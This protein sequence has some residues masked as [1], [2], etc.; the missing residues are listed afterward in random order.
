MESTISDLKADLS[1]ANVSYAGLTEKAQLVE[2]HRRHSR[3][4]KPDDSSEC[5]CRICFEEEEVDELIAPCLCRGT[6]RWVHRSCLDEWRATK[7]SDSFYSCPSCKFKYK[8]R[9]RK[10]PRTNTELWLYRAKVS[11][12]LLFLILALCVVSLI[13]A[14]VA[15]WLLTNTSIIFF[16]MEYVPWGWSRGPE[17]S[18]IRTLCPHT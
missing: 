14:E 4:E 13:M 7:T 9:E 12:D 18:P 3:A 11:G 5:I 17:V 8:L 15:R 16:F 10:D 1:S 6:S 2:L